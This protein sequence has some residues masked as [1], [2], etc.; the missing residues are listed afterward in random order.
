MKKI[1]EVQIIPIKPNDGL[2]AFASCVLYDCLYI[3]S[4]GVH[5]KLDNTGY[6]LT[7]PTKKVGDR[8]INIY[9]PITKNL[10]KAIEKAVF[11]KLKDVTEKSNDR[12]HYSQNS[13]S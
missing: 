13:N 7:Y 6:R 2:I 1:S 11:S 4:M 9:H 8:D 10:S 3:S 5:T 12:Y